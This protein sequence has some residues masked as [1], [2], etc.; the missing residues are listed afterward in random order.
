MPV[1]KQDCYTLATQ[2]PAMPALRAFAEEHAKLEKAVITDALRAWIVGHGA[3]D[4]IDWSAP[5]PARCQTP[6]SLGKTP[7]L[8]LQPI[9]NR[10]VHTV[11]ARLGLTLT[12][13]VSSALAW[14]FGVKP[15]RYPNRRGVSVVILGCG[16]PPMAWD[17][18]DASP[19]KPVLPEPRPVLPETRQTF[20]NPPPAFPSPPRVL[21]EPKRPA[22][23]LRITGP[24]RLETPALLAFEAVR[25]SASE[26]GHPPPKSRRMRDD[27]APLVV[28][29]PDRPE[30]K[31][32]E[33]P[34]QAAV[35]APRVD[36][37]S[38]VCRFCEKR[39]VASAEAKRD[40]G[41]CM[42]CWAAS[43]NHRI[44]NRLTPRASIGPRVAWLKEVHGVTARQAAVLSG[45]ARTT[46]G[47]AAR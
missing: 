40:H 42:T 4:L 16:Y 44:A 21:P 7:T 5:R 37:G 20:P 17:Q 45:M 35:R 19:P 9:V 28:C 26:M 2:H 32:Q 41:A 33:K 29:L 43:L 10:G 25:R 24:V 31:P 39:P 14:R 47:R 6:L 46:E 1:S 15:G 8:Y 11:R 30:S 23:R 22:P 3:G 27:L 34:T 38:V 13:A 12:Q 18:V 36:I